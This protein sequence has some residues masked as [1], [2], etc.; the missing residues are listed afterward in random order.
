MK[1]L[2]V[3]T[4]KHKFKEAS[5]V[6]QNFSVELEQLDQ[7]YEENHDSSLEEIVRSAAKKLADE[8]NQPVVIEDTGLFFEAYNNFPGALPKFVFNSLG[9]EGILKLLEGK[10]RNASFKTIV[11]FC[12]PEQE[13]V[14]FEGIMKGKIILEVKNIDKDVMPYD[15]F[16]VPEGKDKT[17]SEMTLEEKNKLSQRAKAFE[18][19]GKY[20]D[21]K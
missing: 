14:L 15:R 1:I 8:L 9:Y 12:R 4:N 20:I 16:F 17:V 2:F 7:E 10:N 11:G 5:A 21:N 3:T 6:L 19:F 13:S 18:E